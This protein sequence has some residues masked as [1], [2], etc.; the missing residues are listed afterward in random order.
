[1]QNKKVPYVYKDNNLELISPF[2]YAYHFDNSLVAS[3]L[4]KD[5]EYRN[6]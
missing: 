3:Y 5:P 6:N 1:M 4:K 2:Y